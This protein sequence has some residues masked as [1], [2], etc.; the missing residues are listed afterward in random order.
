MARLMEEAGGAIRATVNLVPSLLDQLE[1]YAEGDARDPHL[2]LTARTASELDREERAL[3]LDLFFLAQPDRMI[4][5]WPRYRELYERRRP[6][7][8]AAAQVVDD[9]SVADLTDLQVWANLAWFHRTLLAED[10]GLRALVEKGRGF[11]ED[12]KAFLLARQREVL[13]EVLP[14]HRR[15]AEAGT[16]ELTASPHY[17]PILPLLVS[18]ESARVAL[19]GAR[20]PARRV[21]LVDDARAQ[22]RSA[23]ESHERRFG[24]RPRGLWPSEGSVS[25]G[26]LP[27]VKEEGFDWLASDEG[28]LASSRGAT[29]RREEDL[30]GPWRLAT[31]G[32]DLAVFFRDRALSDAISF[33]YQRMPALSAARDLIAR[34]REQAA[35][36]GRRPALVTLILDGENPWEHYPEGG[37]PFLRALYR[38]LASCDDVETVRLSDYLAEH[39]P[40]RTLERLH[41]GSWIDRNFRIWIGHEEDV[42]AWELLY[43]VREDLLR[44][45][46]GPG[47]VDERAWRSLYAAEGSDWAWWYGD[48]RTSG[49]DHEFD[50][51]YRTHLAN[52]YRLSGREPPPFLSVPVSAPRRTSRRPTGFLQVTVDGEE[53]SFLEW[54]AAGRYRAA[55]GETLV[56]GGGAMRRGDEPVLLEVRFGFDPEILYIRVD[57]AEGWRAELLRRAGGRGRWRLAVCLATS[58]GHCLEVPY[59][60]A[61][62]PRLTLRPGE[63]PRGRWVAVG[64]IVELACPLAALGL[65]AGDET[66]FHLELRRGKDVAERL[67][68]AETVTLGVPGEDFEASEWQV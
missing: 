8:V 52:V 34:V 2:A 7:R 65:R 59:L 46:G 17:H 13:A 58:E 41:S 35:R 15:L 45:G 44:D 22:L 5:P 32:G 18:M 21:P 66:A 30:C 37:V 60:Q 67:P 33:D 64:E 48:D 39:P 49:R 28:V 4:R 26:I 61:K 16:V 63:L 50:V 62:H 55:P 57:L 23:V 38:E 56:G 53:R 36:C 51:L 1:A 29:G 11:D 3:A 54:L 27:L 20:L 12:D 14:L 25:P 19:P 68:G 10:D 6:G 42:R 43:R 31:P 47:N 40:A 24:R 9:F